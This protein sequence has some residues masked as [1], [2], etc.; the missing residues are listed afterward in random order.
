MDYPYYQIE[1]DENIM[2]E[3]LENHYLNK[4]FTRQHIINEVEN[5]HLEHGGFLS[6]SS[7]ALLGMFTQS[8][9][10]IRNKGLY[11][12]YLNKH[13][14]ITKEP[15]KGE[16]NSLQITIEEHLRII[17]TNNTLP[18]ETLYVYYY[19]D[20]KDIAKQKGH[21]I[22][23]MKI[24]Y[25]SHYDARKRVIDQLGTSTNKIPIIAYQVHTPKAIYYEK[26]IHNILHIKNRWIQTGVNK[27]WFMTNHDEI[28]NL[29]I[30]IDQNLVTIS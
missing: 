30:L 3:Y 7:E 13:W 5:Y 11:T 21:T 23:P 16:T 19:P 6:L 2:Q 14:Y 12:T 18:I 4:P 28:M 24:G 8:L 1:L 27:E 17:P 26:A 10:N 20:D 25:T 29:L 22:Y 15:I 9:K